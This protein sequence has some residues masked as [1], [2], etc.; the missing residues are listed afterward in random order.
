MD[1]AV[2]FAAACYDMNRAWEEEDPLTQ[3]SLLGLQYAA[4]KSFAT[5]KRFGGKCMLYGIR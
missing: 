4:V 1:R 5:A 3:V 2:I